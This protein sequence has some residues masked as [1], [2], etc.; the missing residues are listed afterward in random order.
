MRL[1]RSLR[2]RFAI[3]YTCL[4]AVSIIVLGAYLVGSIGDTYSTA[5]EERLGQEVALV[6]EATARYFDGGVDLAGL[7]AAGARLGGLVESRVTIVDTDGTVLL[8]TWADPASIENQATRP[9][10]RGALAT[11][12]GRSTR[13][14]ATDDQEMTYATALITSEGAAVA[15][16]RV[17]LPTS[18]LRSNVNRIIA[19]LALSAMMMALL[20]LVVAFWLAGRTTRSVRSVTQGARRATEGDLDYRVEAF[21]GDETAEL[22]QAFNT[23]A[24]TLRELIEDLSSGRD[25]L[26]VI[27]ETMADGVIVINPDGQTVLMN[28]A[29]EAVLGVGANQ[30]VGRQLAEAVRDHELIELASRALAT[31]TLQQSELDLQRQRRFVS[32]IA[33]P[34]DEIGGGGALLTLHDLTEIRRLD[35]TRREFVSN[36]SH[37]LRSPLASVKALTE[38]LLDGALEEPKTGREFVERINTEADRMTSLV[39]DL[40]ELSRLESGHAKLHLSPV[41]LRRVVDEAVVRTEQEVDARNIRIEIKFPPDLPLVVGEADKLGQVMSN[42]LENSLRVTPDGGAV[43]VSGDSKDRFVELHVTDTGTGIPV[44]HLPHIFE[45]FYKVDRARRD[46]GTGLG[47]AIVKHIV[48]AHGGDVA[49]VSE[50]G[51]GSTF[52]VT[53]PRAS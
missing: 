26:S 29:A 34:L 23:M 20:S 52:S 17:A 43:T 12:L 48:Q 35:T 10:V 11:G 7:N 8:D 45:R 18:Q 49:V 42:L 39:N 38:T 50:E 22:A 16:A 37:E 41:E 33:T 36:V 47:L 1:P 21:A 25:R 4:V 5:L 32:A 28:Q 44:D 46:G 30:A 2:W 53:L 40:L 15:V 3:T 31:R 13:H 51:A 19:S 27:L 6:S 24:S 9:E 14:S